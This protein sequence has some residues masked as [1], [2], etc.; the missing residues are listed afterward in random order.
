MIKRISLLVFIFGICFACNKIEKPKKPDNL[1]AKNDMVNILFDVFVFNAAKGTDKR[2]LEQNNVTPDAYIFE[3]YQIDSL[4]FVKSNA[5]YAYD[6]K[7]YDEM[8]NKVAKR[9]KV[10]KDKFQKEIDLIEKQKKRRLDS[11]KKLGDS[12]PKL[13]SKK[14][15]KAKT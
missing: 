2:I 13:K 15:K 12:L 10:K 7:A 1:I 9:I 11:I 5:Y 4:Q 3:K 14:L 6:I 8:I